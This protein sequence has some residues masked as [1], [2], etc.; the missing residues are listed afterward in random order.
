M[1]AGWRKPEPEGWADWVWGTMAE[2]VGTGDLS[3][4]IF[5]DETVVSWYIEAQAEGIACGIG[6]ANY[7]LQPET[8]EPEKC[9][10]HLLVHD[11]EP[12]S[13]GTK[14]LQGIS[15][16]SRLLTKERTALN[17]VMHLSG[18]AS[19]TAQFVQRVEDF[20]CTI[21]D[22]RK[23]IPG[24]RSL[25]KYAVRCG[26]GTNH[27]MGLYDGIMVKDNHIRAVGGI[28][29]AVQRAKAV[30]GH[31]TMIEVECADVDMVAEAVK[32]GADI[33]MLDNMD[34]FSMQEAT[35]KFR[36]QVRIEASGGVSLETVRAVASTG[37]HA[38]SVGA[39][40][41]SAPALSFHLEV[42]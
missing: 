13:R 28:S 2:D 3:S 41:H 16:A 36:D 21:V 31:M 14:V 7:L 22:T 12:V 23:T 8:D 9:H 37:V 34:P 15:S 32:A 35:K 11:G 18:V 38:I 25:Q 4:A 1:S 29:E 6:L 17:F 26:G 10:C 27:R 33:V 24:M 39:V 30:A 19:L 5:D 20:D 40:T 42:E